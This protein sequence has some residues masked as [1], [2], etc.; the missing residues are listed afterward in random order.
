MTQR[1]VR[2]VTSF[3]LFLSHP[4][5]S[6]ETS[7]CYFIKFWGKRLKMCWCH[8]PWSNDLANPNRA[9]N[10]SP[11]DQKIPHLWG[12][13]EPWTSSIII[14]RNNSKTFC[15]LSYNWTCNI[16]SNS[17]APSPQ[18]IIPWY[19]S[20]MFSGHLYEGQ[21]CTIQGS[22][23]TSAIHILAYHHKDIRLV[24]NA[25]IK[26]FFLLPISVQNIPRK[27]SSALETFV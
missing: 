1:Y 7:V 14:Q 11:G 13:T 26:D 6:R 12:V 19:S 27:K 18:L 16:L 20:Q 23:R 2:S 3:S 25:R 15:D 22:N 17:K 24:K 9:V 8:M 21:H 5:S 4:I 10:H